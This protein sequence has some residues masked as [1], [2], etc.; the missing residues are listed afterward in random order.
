MNPER[1]RKSLKSLKVSTVIYIVCAI[2]SL[3]VLF[4]LPDRT[5][6]SNT[7]AIVTLIIGAVGLVSNW[8]S[9]KRYR[10]WAQEWQEEQYD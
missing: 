3:A 2:S 9:A 8:F 4:V 7:L 1:L 10:K 5:T 6:L